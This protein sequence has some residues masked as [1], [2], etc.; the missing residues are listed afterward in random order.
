MSPYLCRA[1]RDQFTP[2][3][4]GP[5]YKPW[6]QMYKKKPQNFLLFQLKHATL[7]SPEDVG[8][9]IKNVGSPPGRFSRGSL[10]RCNSGY[11]MGHRTT[12][13]AAAA[14]WLR[15]LEFKNTHIQC[16]FTSPF[17]PQLTPTDTEVG[18]TVI[19]CEMLFLHGPCSLSGAYIKLLFDVGLQRC[20]RQAAM[21]T[22]VFIHWWPAW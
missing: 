14:A 20:H 2:V 5:C 16:I 4:F 22:F 3:Y 19:L 13:Q 17:L 12:A 9:P 7:V 10:Q 1:E 8:K 18:L 15:K 21:E 11:S 6:F